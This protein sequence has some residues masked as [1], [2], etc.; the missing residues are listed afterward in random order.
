MNQVVI[1]E[2]N[3]LS[4]VDWYCS[5]SPIVPVT[6]GIYIPIIEGLTWDVVKAIKEDDGSIILVEDPVKVKA[7]LDA[8]WTQVRTQQKHKLYE[9]DWTCS[10]T[11]YTPPNKPEWIAYRQALRDV[12]TQTD[13]FNILWPV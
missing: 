12:T 9:S 8:A 13:P 10:V 3:T 4:I 6:D 5:D 11:D 1:L 2:S 7:K